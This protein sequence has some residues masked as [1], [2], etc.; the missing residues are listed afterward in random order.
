MRELIAGLPLGRQLLPFLPG[1][2]HLLLITPLALGYGTL[3]FVF[4]G[5]LK[6]QRGVRTAYTRKV[7]HFAIFTMASIVHLIW[8]LPG[9][10]VFGIVIMLLVCYA[11]YRGDQH[12]WYEA[13]ARP[14][15]QPQRTLFILIP[16]ITTILGGFLSNVLF[17]AFSYVGYLV[18]GS[19]DAVGEPVGSRW[20]KHAYR[21]PSLAGVPAKRTL[22]GSTAV[23]VVGSIA[24]TVGLM[25]GGLTG[26]HALQVG[27]ACGLAGAVVEAI[28]TH[29]L[30]N[31]TTQLIASAVAQ[32]LA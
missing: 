21:V 31:L 5:W 18:C 10:V 32:L 25:A 14:S 2:H 7:F 22:E 24:A 1:I 3:A 12:P 16:L 23:F 8:S 17:P 28:S 26:A 11:V 27:V 9:V 20:G 13:L 29:G 15:D 4:A 30:D 19:G 6:T